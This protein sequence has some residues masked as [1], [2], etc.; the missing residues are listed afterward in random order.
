MEA[1]QSGQASIFSFICQVVVG[2]LL[3][4][5]DAFIY[6]GRFSG[7]NMN[8]VP[9]FGIWELYEIENIANIPDI[10]EYGILEYIGTT[11]GFRVQKAYPRNANKRVQIRYRGDG[12]GWTEWIEL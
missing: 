3:N 5:K 6:R 8:D 4:Y 9:E 1:V 12:T 2:E 7:S 11:V 10:D